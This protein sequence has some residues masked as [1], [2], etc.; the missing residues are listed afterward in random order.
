MENA[1][2]L[3]VQ[4]KRQQHFRP[5]SKIMLALAGGDN[6]DQDL[7]GCFGSADRQVAQV[8]LM[9]PLLYCWKA[10]AGAV[11]KRGV[12]YLRKILV[13]D[14][15]VGSRQ[16][17]VGRTLLWRPSVSGPRGSA[18]PKENSILLR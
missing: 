15:A 13:D 17:I 8:A 10:R 1:G 12:Q 9:G 3:S 6:E 5:I 16:N 18:S 11:V 2:D 4:L 7:A 14:F